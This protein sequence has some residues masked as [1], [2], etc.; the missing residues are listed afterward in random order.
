MAAPSSRWSRRAAVL[1]S[2]GRNHRP[3]SHFE[4]AAAAPFLSTLK[5]TTFEAGKRV[6]VEARIG[7]GDGDPYRNASHEPGEFTVPEGFEVELVASEETGL[8]K[9]TMVAFDDAG[10]MWS[11]TAT[12]YPCDKD[13]II[14]TQPGKDRIVVFD[15]PTAR[16]PQTARTFAEGMVMPVSLLPHGKGVFVAQGPEIFYLDDRDGD[17]HADERRVLAKGFGVQ[18]THTVPHQLTWMPGGRVVFSQGLLNRGTMTDAAGTS[19]VHN[20]SEHRPPRAAATQRVRRAHGLDLAVLRVEFLQRP[21]AHELALVPDGPEG[22]VGRAEFRQVQCEH[23]L[24]RRIDGEDMA[25]CGAHFGSR[26]VGEGRG[27]EPRRLQGQAAGI[28]T[29]L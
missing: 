14:W 9:P 7:Y 26:N 18:D 8:P 20:V 23:L 22:D 27:F 13:N 16:T 6:S 28:I 24:R 1:R 17:G 3:A 10:R 4:N 25:F 21:A 15:T 11:A 12:A 5:G 29:F 2:F 19:F